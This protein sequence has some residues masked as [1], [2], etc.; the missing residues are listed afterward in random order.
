MYLS[1]SP[2]QGDSRLRYLLEPGLTKLRRWANPGMHLLHHLEMSKK[3]PA[4][5]RDFQIGDRAR[6]G[7]EKAKGQSQAS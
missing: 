7:D 2:G 1:N 4:V 5:G 6:K 3:P